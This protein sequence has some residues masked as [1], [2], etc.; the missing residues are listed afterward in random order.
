MLGAEKKNRGVSWFTDRDSRALHGEPASQL[1]E[2]LA[3]ERRL[4]LPDL[5]G[6]LLRLER[7]EAFFFGARHDPGAAGTAVQ[8][9]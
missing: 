9:S 5:P 2:P 1:R 7:A 4:T 6:D 3:V 8:G